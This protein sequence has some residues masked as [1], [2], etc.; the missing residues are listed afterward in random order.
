MRTKDSFLYSISA[1]SDSACLTAQTGQVAPLPLTAQLVNHADGSA[2]LSNQQVTFAVVDPQNGVTP[3]VWSA[4]QGEWASSTAVLTN[5]GGL[6]SVLVKA[7]TANG[8]FKIE[9]RQVEAVNS[10]ATFALTVGT[11]VPDNT[12]HVNALLIVEGD[13]QAAFLNNQVFPKP[14][15]VKAIDASSKP[16]VNAEIN[17]RATGSTGC[18]LAPAPPVFTGAGGLTP[19][20][21]LFVGDQPGKFT[22]VAEAN[23]K[24]ATFDLALAPNEDQF[25]FSTADGNGITITRGVAPQSVQIFLTD[26]SKTPWPYIN[27]Y[28]LALPNN[29]YFS[30][31]QPEKVIG[32]YQTTSAG[33]VQLDLGA[34]EVS[35]GYLAVW[36][37]SA[38]SQTFKV[39][40]APTVGE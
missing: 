40:V 34:T 8:H 18:T 17:F 21:Q 9:A 28:A 33:G 4:E 39:A 16:V 10:P 35:D 14:L 15:M 6:A 20:L 26:T 19:M 3:A 5:E 37:G 22:V 36:V 30:G 12:G 23:G 25:G 32:P 11:G 27:V 1:G 29:L 7:G 38:I 2:P 24:Q 31:N 13:R